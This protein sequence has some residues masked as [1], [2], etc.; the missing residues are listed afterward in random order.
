MDTQELMRRYAELAVKVGVN[1]ESGQHV[2]IN[3]LIDHVPFVREVARAAYE[4]GAGYVDVNYSD[5][6][7]K[8]A[9]L[10]LAPEE[11][12]TFTPPYLIKKTQDMAENKGATINI[13]GDPEPDLFADLDPQRVGNA[14]M[15]EL[16][17]LYTQLL[18]QRAMAW[19]IVAYPTE[20]WARTVF[21]EPDVDKLW[22]AVGKAARLYDDDPVSSW[23]SRVETLGER[24]QLLNKHKFDAI[25]YQGPSTDL[26]VGLL[27]GSTWMSAD[28]ETTWGRK[29][30]P[31][32]P[33]EEVFTSPDFRRVE[34]VIS[35]TRP[36]HLP[37]EGVTVSDLK[38]TFKDG[39]AVD[40]EASS[41]AEV[42]RIQMAI[43]EGA[44]RLGELALVD[45]DSA[46]G[47][48]GVTFA[49]TLFDENATSHIAYGAGF[50]FCVDGASD[51]SPDEQVGIGL[52]YSK[53]HTDFMVGGPE[54]QIDGLTAS[55]D[56]VPIIH[57]DTWQLS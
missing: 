3:G 5:K 33:T 32:I 17:D 24:A 9:M 51:L 47:Q 56:A 1:V 57:N 40:V 55:G 11:A 16:S 4:A 29:H 54:V 46:V 7:V 18:G 6:H 28:F 45:K 8:K 19:V 37:N 25:R 38:L 15:L 49:N 21:G 34:G 52:N 30:V 48:T 13:A 14:R 42:I 2:T 39:R 22:E 43:D 20:G 53:V 44:A 41:G 26:T 23:W 35:S 50:S 36:L 31:N 27:P 10:E 12:L